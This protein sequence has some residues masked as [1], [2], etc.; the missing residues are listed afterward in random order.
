MRKLSTEDRTGSIVIAALLALARR[1][2][3]RLEIPPQE[4]SAQ[5]GAGIV[6]SHEPG[7]EAPW[8]FAVA[9]ER[10][11]GELDDAPTVFSPGSK[12]IQ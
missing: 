12:L 2:G 11:K 3:G 6:I 10:E 5:I 8:I 4:M 1:N 7:L 9:P